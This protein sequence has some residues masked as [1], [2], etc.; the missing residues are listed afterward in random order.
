MDSDRSIQLVFERKPLWDEPREDYHDRDVSRKLWAEV[1]E[2]LKEPWKYR[3]FIS[4]V[5]NSF[6]CF[7]LYKFI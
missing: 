4:N 7:L 6:H 3:V 2:E 1:A 5:N